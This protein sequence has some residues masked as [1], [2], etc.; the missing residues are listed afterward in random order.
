MIDGK[1]LIEKLLVYA[2]AFLGLNALDVIYQRNYLLRLFGFNSPTKEK[3]TVSAKEQIRS[4]QVPDVLIEEI[5]AFALENKLAENDIEA[6]LF[7]NFVMGVLSPRPSEVNNM[8]MS[9]KE[10]RGSQ[11]ACDYLYNLCIKN[12]Y[13]RKSAIDKN[14]K[15]DADKQDIPFEVTIN[16]SKPE[17]DNKDVAKLL[18]APKT[19]KYPE[20]NLCK[21]NEGF[22]GTLTQPARTN[23]RTISLTLAG[24]EWAMQYSPY[25]YFDEHCIL[26][27]KKHTPMCVNGTTVE[28]LFDFIELFPNYFLGS[29]AD[30]PIVGGSIL[31]HEHYQGGK[32]A[33]PLHKAKAFE[34]YKC[35]DYPDTTIEVV[36]FY[37]SVVRISGYN[38]NT[39][40]ALA[41]EVIEKWKGYF[42]ES[43]MIIA[44]SDGVRHNTVTPIARFLSDSRYCIE[45]ILRN[46]LTTDEYP[47]GLYHAH[48]EY[49]NVKKE[50]IGLI[51]SMGLYVLPARLKR[52][53]SAIADILAHK[54][55]YKADEISKEDNDLFVHRDM[56]AH[57]MKKHPR[58]KDVKKANAVITEYVNDVCSK[59]LYNTSVFGKDSKGVLAFNK[60]LATCNIK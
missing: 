9:L 25:L 48:P 10:K 33:M 4:M 35:E 17:K 54:V 14:V 21:E 36:D 3:L 37:N 57:L 32:H 59:I 51:E 50:G 20:C 53:F 55:E 1:L 15:W 46:N 29:N 13:V 8:F 44:E 31:N 30:L 27:S 56:I 47:D 58:I 34:T 23:L 11:T 60:F 16:L 28:R 26:F 18:T 39:V 52:Q 6:D 45:L 7:A 19:E 12:Y 42:D 43:V 2:D 41:T 24:E 22:Y 49:H 5:T 40:Q 38:R